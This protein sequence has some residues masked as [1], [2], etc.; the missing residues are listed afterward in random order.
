MHSS[1]A[2]H[3]YRP[4]TD[5]SA[6]LL[7]SLKLLRGCQARKWKIASLFSGMGPERKVADLTA[8]DC[9]CVFAYDKS[10]VSCR[11]VLANGHVV[12]DHIFRCP[13]SIMGINKAACR[14]HGCI[15]AC[16]AV[17][18]KGHLDMLIVGFSCKSSS[19]TRI[20]RERS[21]CQRSEDDLMYGFLQSLQKLEP[22]QCFAESI[23]G[24]LEHNRRVGCA[25]I[26]RFMMAFL[27]MGLASRYAVKRYIVCDSLYLTCR[28]R[29]VY[30]NF[31][32]RRVGD[33]VAA[34][35]CSQIGQD[36]VQ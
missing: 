2:D 25:P 4:Y 17:V 5:D 6:K 16:G 34:G 12:C 23:G 3:G 26:H 30:I 24:C 32:H 19:N 20:G 29:C 18:P 35:R 9:Q 11:F 27:E 21:V 33:H 8:L 36:S 14:A 7:A 15:H 31:V 22:S 13:R 28:G 1:I 10:D